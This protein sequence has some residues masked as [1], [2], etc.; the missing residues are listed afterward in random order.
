MDKDKSLTSSLD[1]VENSLSSSCEME[2]NTEDTTSQPHNLVQSRAFTA[3]DM[4]EVQSGSTG[5]ATHWKCKPPIVSLGLSTLNPGKAVSGIMQQ[6]MKPFN[7]ALPATSQQQPSRGEPPPQTSQVVNPF[8]R[9]RP[10]ADS[11]VTPAW[12]MTKTCLFY[13]RPNR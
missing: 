10:P 7:R 8:A 3:A 12:K 11:K 2:H 1:A 5:Q 4:D 6:G 13:G 9:T